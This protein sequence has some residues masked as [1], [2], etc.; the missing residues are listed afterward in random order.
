[1]IT[2]QERPTE[3][4][5]TPATLPSVTTLDR[6]EAEGFDI[7]WTTR[8]ELNPAAIMFSAGKDSACVLHLAEKAF[9]TSRGSL[10]FPF[11]LSTTIV[12]LISRR[13]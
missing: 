2:L 6:L 8:A 4:V 7:L 3:R 10:E 9:R 12:G 11:S 1:M 5:A 13:Y